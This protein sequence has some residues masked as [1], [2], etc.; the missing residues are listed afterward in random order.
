ME[1]KD[2]ADVK[3][4][5]EI[6]ELVTSEGF[7]NMPENIQ[8]KAL[9]SIEAKSQNEGGWMGRIFG[10][11]KRKC[12]YEYSFY[13]VWYTTD[14]LRHRYNSC[15]FD[16]KSSIYRIGKGSN[17]CSNFDIRIHIWKK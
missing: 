7:K 15:S 4:Y 9:N 11:K 13:I 17:S 14:F 12:C 8:E 16:W 2:G 10:T 3:I 1:E 6:T 5:A